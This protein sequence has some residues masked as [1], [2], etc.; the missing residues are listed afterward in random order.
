MDIYSLLIS[1]MYYH[2]YGTMKN[3][4]KSSA[5]IELSQKYILK[6]TFPQTKDYA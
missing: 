1:R 6:L 5:F 3:L 4:I 2:C